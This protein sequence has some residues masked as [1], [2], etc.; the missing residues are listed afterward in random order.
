MQRVTPKLPDKK[1][2]FFFNSPLILMHLTKHLF[3]C[4]KYIAN[5]VCLSSSFSSKRTGKKIAGMK[6][7]K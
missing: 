4:Y 1:H 2:R 7:G 5:L 6:H 3:H